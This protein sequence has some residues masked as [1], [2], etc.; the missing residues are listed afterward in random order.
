MSPP[1][2]AAPPRNRPVSLIDNMN[3]R[4]T[5][6]SHD[7]NKSKSQTR[8]SISHP[9]PRHS[10]RNS[11]QNPVPHLPTNTRN[12]CQTDP[13]SRKI[14]HTH[15]L[16]TF[17]EDDTYHEI[18]TNRANINCW[19]QYFH[20]DLPRQQADQVLRNQAPGSFLFRKS[21]RDQS[22]VMTVM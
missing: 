16:E 7:Y 13:T 5:Y 19:E 9:H 14:R 3:S 15:N 2:R 12:R 11:F 20:G 1:R 10:S 18:T 21:T 17:D 22:I 4:H 8:H 6:S